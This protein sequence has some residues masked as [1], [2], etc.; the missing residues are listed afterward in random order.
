MQK[1]PQWT[2]TAVQ[3]WRKDSFMR[4]QKPFIANILSTNESNRYE[5]T[6]HGLPLTYV[7]GGHICVLHISWGKVHTTW[8]RFCYSHP[9]SCFAPSEAVE[10]ILLLSFF[11]FLFLGPW[12]DKKGGI[13]RNQEHKCWSLWGILRYASEHSRHLHVGWLCYVCIPLREGD[14]CHSTSLFQRASV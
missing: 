2:C 4:M 14:M 10:L 1:N 6:Y 8:T 12:H 9:A 11:C 7:R 13:N 5:T 3:S